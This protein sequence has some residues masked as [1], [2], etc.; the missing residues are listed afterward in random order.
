MR[1]R[2]KDWSYLS[3][4]SRPHLADLVNAVSFAGAKTIGLDVY[5]DRRWD[6][7]NRM[8]GGDDRLRQALAD[9]GNVILVSM[10]VDSE[11][12]ESKV[13]ADPDPYFAEVAAGVASADL[14]RLRDHPRRNAD[15]SIRRGGSLP[16]S[17]W[18]CTRTLGASTSTP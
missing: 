15:C 4:F 2:T 1:K 12:G 8:D 6:E 16:D 14:P 13:L 18:R 11:D 10:V 17:L 9:A 7:L 3:P 5:L